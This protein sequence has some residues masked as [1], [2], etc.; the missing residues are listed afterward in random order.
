MS[1]DFCCIFSLSNLLNF[2]IADSHQIIQKQKKI[3]LCGKR[4]NGFIYI[5]FRLLWLIKKKTKALNLYGE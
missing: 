3:E 4:T 1:F 2:P 5:F